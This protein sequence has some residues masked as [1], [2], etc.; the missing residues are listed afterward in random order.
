[1]RFRFGDNWQSYAKGIGEKEIAEAKRSLISLLGNDLAGRRFPDVGSGSGLF[2][3]AARAGSAPRSF[4]STMMPC[5][6]PAPKA[7][8]QNIRWMIEIGE[9]NRDR[10]WTTPT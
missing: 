1:M 6:S 2:S 5:P 8:A 7:Y 4:H 3:L 9:S 10:F